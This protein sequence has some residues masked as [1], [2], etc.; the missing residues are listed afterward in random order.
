ML[1]IEFCSTGSR[2]MKNQILI[3]ILVSLI[4]IESTIS[5]SIGQSDGQSQNATLQGT[6]IYPSEFLPAQKVCAKNVQ[7]TKLFCFETKQSQTDFSISVK[8]GTYEIFARECTKSYQTNIVC[9]DSYRPQR[10]YYNEHAKCG[11]TA[12]CAKK[13]KRNRPILVRIRSGQTIANIKPHDWYSN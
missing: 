11:I 9:R 12:E 4:S 7:T 1:L 5:S 13:F 3:S 8:A 10:A 2:L 6:V